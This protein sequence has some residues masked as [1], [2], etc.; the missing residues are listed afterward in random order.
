MLMNAMTRRIGVAFRPDGRFFPG[1]RTHAGNFNTSPMLVFFHDGNLWSDAR[2]P[3]RSLR[4]LIPTPCTTSPAII[5]N[6]A[7]VLHTTSA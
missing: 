2:Q 6:S 3:V 1:V 7:S 5:A 4:N